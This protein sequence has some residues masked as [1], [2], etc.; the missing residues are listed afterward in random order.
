VNP[1]FEHLRLAAAGLRGSLRVMLADAV[2]C[3]V[4]GLFAVMAAVFGLVAGYA[5]LLTVVGPIW[6]PVI[7]AGVFMA[8]ALIL[9]VFRAQRRPRP[10]LV[11]VAAPPVQPQTAD[12]GLSA[13]F[14]VGFLCTRWLF[15]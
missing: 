13:A 5:A 12:A 15:R 6:T 11:P 9:A 2:L 10:I 3:A 7:L 8:M 14:L 4:I 1:L